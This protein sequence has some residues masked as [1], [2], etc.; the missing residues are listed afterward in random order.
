MN[1]RCW[2]HTATAKRVNFIQIGKYK[3]DLQFNNGLSIRLSRPRVHPGNFLF[4][5]MFFPAAHFLSVEEIGVI[6]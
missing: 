1:F 3:D 5:E 6:A 4:Q 2:T